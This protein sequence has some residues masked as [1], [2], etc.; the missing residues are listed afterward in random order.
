MTMPAFGYILR[1]ADGR[2]Y[3]GSTNDL[4]QR[5]RRHRQGQ[6]HSTARRLPVQ[7]AYFEE[8]ETLEHAKQREHSFKSGR[9]RRKA[10]ER[11]IIGFAA[12]RL[13]PFA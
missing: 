12:H 2:Y 9:T 4:L 13:A 1:C 6:V 5:L 10:I 8:F 7:L 11:L 3:H